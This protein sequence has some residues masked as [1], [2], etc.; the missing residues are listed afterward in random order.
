[1]PDN[2]GI[3]C[4]DQ[5]HGDVRNNDWTSQGPYASMSE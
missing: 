4:T 3:D 5:W 2:C 1:V